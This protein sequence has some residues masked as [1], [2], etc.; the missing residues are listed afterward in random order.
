MKR[1]DELNIIIEAVK[2]KKIALANEQTFEK[3]CAFREFEKKLLMEKED[4]EK[5]KLT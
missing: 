1:L 3:A 4:L 2:K 5:E